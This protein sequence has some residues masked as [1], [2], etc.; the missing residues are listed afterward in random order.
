MQGIGNLG[1]SMMY[2]R[3][4]KCIVY[5]SKINKL[6][7]DMIWLHFKHLEII[8]KLIHTTFFLLTLTHDLLV[9]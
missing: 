4:T 8:M 7:V 1:I 6:T 5:I 3:V 2:C 9:L